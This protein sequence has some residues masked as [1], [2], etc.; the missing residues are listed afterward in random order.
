[1]TT[2]L[3]SQAI[4]ATRLIEQFMPESDVRELHETVVHA[5]A[6]MV[7][8][9]AEHLDLQSIPLVRAIFWLRGML[10][11]SRRELRMPQGLV[12]ETARLGWGELARRAGR[13]LVMGA[14]TQP[15]HADVRFTAI[16]AERFREFREPDHVK[17][18]WTLEAVPIEPALTLFRSETRVVAT[19]AAA[20]AQ[21]LR[22]WRWARLGIVLIRLLHLPALR[23]AAER[24]YRGRE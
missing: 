9:V 7:F 13:E 16:P 2:A 12:A 19:D 10:M 17:I 20:R 15:W 21:F 22:Y 14:A 8:D 18:V 1:M 23:R 6:D 3:E 24:R 4:R 5:P 11:G